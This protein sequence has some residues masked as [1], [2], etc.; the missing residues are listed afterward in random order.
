MTL[1]EESKKIMV[2][3]YRS[4]NLT[5]IQQDIIN[6]AIEQNQITIEE[7]QPT[8]QQIKTPSQ[9]PAK[10]TQ[11]QLELIPELAGTQR[12]QF[13]GEPLGV[14]ETAKGALTAL[15]YAYSAITPSLGVAG[16]VASL[17]SP[18]VTGLSETGVGLLEGETPK[19]A[20]MRGIKAAGV[21]TA[22]TG[23]LKAARGILPALAKTA[24]K[25]DKNVI[26]KVIKDPDLTKVEPKSNLEITEIIDDRLSEFRRL[27]SKQYEKEFSK[28]PR[29][30]LD[31]PITKTEKV[32]DF[33]SDP[34][35]K[36]NI[37]E[38]I[39]VIKNEKPLGYA[40]DLT[41][42]DR[43][44]AGQPITP[45]EIKEVNS[46]LSEVL[47]SK[48]LVPRT[49]KNLIDIKDKVF[50]TLSDIS[51]QIAKIN[52][53]YTEQSKKLGITKKLQEYEVN[54]QIADTK[55][56]NLLT[57][58]G[59]SLGGKRYTREKV[60][61]N[62]DKIDDELNIPKSQKIETI[63]KG[64]VAQEIIQQ[65]ASKPSG[66][67]DQVLTTLIS[68][69][70]GTSFYNPV[71]GAS[72][73]GPSLATKIARTTPVSQSLLKTAQ[74]QQRF[75]EPIKQSGK[76]ASI[77]FGQREARAEDGSYSDTAIDFIK[78]QRGILKN[79]GGN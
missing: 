16:R 72:I 30:V 68:L 38:I 2:N 36:I 41:S 76:A 11:K 55:V 21:E 45:D 46:L 10:F 7:L 24:S 5:P 26:D 59:K 17:A 73:A 63:M 32:T 44:F 78:K 57:Q 79:I 12:N 35:N 8:E 13:M 53:K 51:P 69:G 39:N 71:M 50:K 47:R 62:L 19:E 20:S 14:K 25:A 23:I 18:L 58:I 66:T 33:I 60:I 22:M 42:V 67:L 6:R 28:I 40:M 48:N 54:P 34:K 4:G 29:K 37:Q 52:E 27:R 64:T 74:A 31:T 3:A 1:S 15:P 70:G 49:K 75:I 61:D 56:S 77:L 9:Q 65:A 43:L